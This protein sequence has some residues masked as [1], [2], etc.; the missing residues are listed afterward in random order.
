MTTLQSHNVINKMASIGKGVKKDFQNSNSEESGISLECLN[1]ALGLGHGLQQ[2]DGQGSSS[3]GDQAEKD[4]GNLDA[5]PKVLDKYSSI[6]KMGLLVSSKWLLLFGVKPIGKCSFPPIKF[7]PKKQ[8]GSC[9]I[10]I[11]DELVEH[12]IAVMASTLVGKFIG[13]RPNIDIL[14][15]FIKKKW[16]LNRQV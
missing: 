5:P 4:D 6:P 8:K 14:R 3:T 15:S 11:P 13:P 9:A 12:R 16:A 1:W 10:S 2:E 7:L